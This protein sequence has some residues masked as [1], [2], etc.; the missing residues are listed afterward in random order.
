[1][2]GNNKVRKASEEK[3]SRLQEG[4]MEINTRINR[5]EKMQNNRI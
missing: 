1:M 4:E 5:K 2:K 3:R